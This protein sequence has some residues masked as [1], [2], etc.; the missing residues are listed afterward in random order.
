MGS[1]TVKVTG[2]RELGEAMRGLSRE[3]NLKIARSATGRAA[4]VIRKRAR[5]LA[6]VYKEDYVVK[7]VKVPRGNVRDNIVAKRV[8]P[9]ETRFTSE[10]LVV[11]RGGRKNGYASLIAAFD[12]FGTVKMT[13]RPFM[14]PA[15]DQEKGFAVG[16]IKQAIAE[17]IAKAATVKK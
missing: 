9:S 11:V 6:P 4:S 8:S 10:H 7:G 1:V 13:P 3:M 5:E 16:R 12:E 2:L 17:G 14:R 15:F